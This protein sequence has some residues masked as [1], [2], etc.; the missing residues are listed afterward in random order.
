MAYHI[1]QKTSYGII[2]VPHCGKESNMLFYTSL[3]KV[4]KKYQAVQ[5]IAGQ[6]AIYRLAIAFSF[7]QA[8][9]P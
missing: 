9:G 5:M 8:S 6:W 4:V 3:Y 7:G 2:K 1:V